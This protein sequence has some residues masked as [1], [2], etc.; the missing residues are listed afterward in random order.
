MICVN[1]HDDYQNLFKSEIK[2]EGK[3]GNKAKLVIT[4]D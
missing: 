2:V 1:A 4:P 3:P